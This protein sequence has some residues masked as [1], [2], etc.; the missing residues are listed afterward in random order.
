MLISSK[1]YDLLHSTVDFRVAG[2]SPEQGPAGIRVLKLGKLLVPL[3]K[4]STKSNNETQ[5]APTAVQLGGHYV[6]PYIF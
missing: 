5:P 3:F 4:F 1:S 2:G 6:R